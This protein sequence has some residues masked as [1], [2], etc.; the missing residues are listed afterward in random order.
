MHTMLYNGVDKSEI[1]YYNKLELI[2][3]QCIMSKR[4]CKRQPRR[5]LPKGVAAED[6]Q[7][8]RSDPAVR[9]I[10]APLSHSLAESYRTS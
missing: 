2:E 6:A 9:L 10:S 8:Q 4:C 3:A 7:G 5:T 1:R